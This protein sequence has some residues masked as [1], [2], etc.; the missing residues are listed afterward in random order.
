MIIETVE[1]I[2]YMHKGRTSCYENK[3]EEGRE[4]ERIGHLLWLYPE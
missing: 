1:K 4:W 2:L 3:R